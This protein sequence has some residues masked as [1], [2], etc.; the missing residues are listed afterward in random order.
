[1]LARLEDNWVQ[2]GFLAAFVLFALAPLAIA[3]WSRSDQ[4]VYLSLPVYMI[5]QYEEHDQDRFRRFVNAVIGGGQDVLSP[6]DVLI[7]NIVGVWAVLVVTAWLALRAD[8]SF[9]LVAAYLL[10]VNAVLHV[11]QAIA[12]HRSNPGLITAVA[13]FLPLGGWLFALLAPGADLRHHLA[14]AGF[15]LLV[16]GLIVLRVLAKKHALMPSSRN[17]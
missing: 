16:H 2:G 17:A 10:L 11:A 14:A 3:D 6:F 7:I 1:M 13:L 12:L 15:V 8:P 5:H 9:G 4:L